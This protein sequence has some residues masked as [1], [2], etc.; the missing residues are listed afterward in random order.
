MIRFAPLAIVA[1]LIAAP[2]FA[3]NSPVPQGTPAPKFAGLEGVDG[4]SYSLADMKDKDVLVLCFTCNHCPVAMAYEDRVI[5]F[6]KKHCGDASKVGFIAIG[7]N[8]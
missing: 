1:T 5:G 4:K 6:V 3:Q 2:A 8:D 7:C